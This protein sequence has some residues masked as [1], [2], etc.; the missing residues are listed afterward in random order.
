MQVADSDHTHF[1]GDARHGDNVSAHESGSVPPGL[2]SHPEPPH[3]QS[4]LPNGDQGGDADANA[5]SAPPEENAPA[6]PPSSEGQASSPSA[7]SVTT[8]PAILAVEP[9]TQSAGD[10][11]GSSSTQTEQQANGAA[12]T[13]HPLQAASSSAT[14]PDTDAQLIGTEHFTATQ[15]V[16]EQHAPAPHPITVEAT[17]LLALPSEAH[18]TEQPPSSETSSVT[19]NASPAT[20]AAPPNEEPAQAPKSDGNSAHVPSANR[21]SISYAAGTRRMVIDAGVV[22][23]LK[24]FRSDARIEVHMTIS[25]DN[26]HLKGILVRNLL[27]S[28]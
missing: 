25:E 2:G 24:V 26:G 8:M 14:I 15:P 7:I 5:P 22:E 3:E 23:K 17:Q 19:L 9:V 21:L 1:E 18:D 20:T 16:D 27:S 4:G 11:D 13:L 10:A 12:S 6:A 28:P